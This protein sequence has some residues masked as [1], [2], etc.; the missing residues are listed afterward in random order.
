VIDVH[1]IA[2]MGRLREDL[3]LDPHRLKRLRVQFYKNHRG[4]ERALAELPEPAR[5]AARAQIRFHRLRLDTAKD[6]ET[7]GAT[8]LIFRTHDDLRIETVILRVQSGRTALCVSSQVGCGADC[9]FC[10]TGKLGLRRNLDATEILDQIVQANQRVAAEGRQ[11]RNIVFMGMG[12]PLH[13]E[14]NLHQALAVLRDK[15]CFHHSPG[16]VSVSTVGVPDAMRRFVQES[17]GVRLALSLH[18]ARQTTREAI[19]P[20]ARRYDLDALRAAVEEVSE[21]RCG[22][23]MLEYL[24][25]AGVN[26]QPED[27]DQLDAWARDLHVH[28]NLIPYNEIPGTPELTP[29]PRPHREAFANELKARG[30][31]VTLRYSLGS[32]ITA[33]CGQLVREEN[34]R[35]PTG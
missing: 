20:L 23:V 27:L 1:D 17:P 26:D 34:R 7:D 29:T 25:L 32:D 31:K 28:I 13:N 21:S 35:Y 8:K 10:A 24:L 4:A 16:Q 9:A 12:E 6:S 11:V 5:S 33:A 22:A 19:I 2:A 3:G 18:S 30:H 15:D 14:S